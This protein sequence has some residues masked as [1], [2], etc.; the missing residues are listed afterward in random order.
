MACVA[1]RGPYHRSSSG[2]SVCLSVV[3]IAA[4]SCTRE[5]RESPTVVRDSG[6]VRIIENPRVSIAS[7][8]C[9]V[10]SAVPVLTI[11]GTSADGPS[12]F[13]RVAGAR[14]LPNG[15]IAVLDGGSHE[16][17][18]F[19]T[20][21]TFVHSSGRRGAGPGEFRQPSTLDRN[22]DSL[23]VYDLAGYRLTSLDARGQ[24]TG[25]VAVPDAVGASVAGV[26]RDGSLIMLKQ[27]TYG[28]SA[29]PGVRR[30][31]MRVIRV[32]LPGL[33]SDT[34]AVVA[35]A[36]VVIVS[37]GSGFLVSALPFGRNTVVA[38]FGDRIY[39]ADN[40][41]YRIRVHTLDGR[42]LRI[43]QRDYTPEQV[44]KDDL[45]QEQQ[46]RAFGSGDQSYLRYQSQLMSHPGIPQTRAPFS[47]IV[48]DSL[49]WLWVLRNSNGL[50]SMVPWDVFDSAG[51]F[52]CT[53]PLPASLRITEIGT[54]FLLGIVVDSTDEEQVR[55]YTVSR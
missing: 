43:I 34:L 36:E 53:L 48:L 10:V 11:G 40:A 22:G 45:Q 26:T 55:Q 19:D 42:L 25:T 20:L 8:A 29:T 15:A 35:G 16:V 7:E 9:P 37:T 28:A 54:D 47:R 38:T 33:D 14:R 12:E 2:I 23:F 1:G 30:D 50:A 17:R 46:R 18:L 5:V 6:S 49:S 13:V 51:V 21:G 44:T 27:A 41:E 24:V 32:M 3:A 31:S 39:I 4:F 52:Q